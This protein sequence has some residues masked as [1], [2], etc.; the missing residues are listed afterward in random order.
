MRWRRIDVVLRRVGPF[1]SVDLINSLDRS[2]DWT[3]VSVVV[4]GIGIAG[5]AAADAL[6]S[7]GAR[8]HVIDGADT[9]KTRERA[10]IL[11]VLGARITLGDGDTLPDELDV[12]VVSPGLPPSAPVIQAAL[13]RGIPVWGELE[14]AWRL[15]KDE[16]PWLLVT[17][18]NGKTTTTLMLESM[19][20]ASGLRTV[21][22]G[23]IGH[24]LVDVVMHDTVD[25]IAVEVGAPQLPFV[26]TV[27]PLAAVCLNVA[28]DHIDH[29]GS[30]EAYIA[31][32]AKVFERTQIAAVY[33]AADPITL[34]MVEDADVIEGCRAV[35]FT[36]GVPGL[37][38]LGLVDEYLVDRAFIEERQ[39]AAQELAS[40]SDVVPNA[41]H[42]VA[43]ALAAAALARA[44]GV[45]A[46]SI[47]QG[48]R[49]FTPAG[50]RITTVATISE[51]TFVDDSKATNTHAAQTALQA[52]ESVVWIAGGMAKGQEFDELVVKQAHRLRGVVL[53]G[54]DRHVIAQ[55]LARHAPDVPVLEVDRTDT[56]AMADVVSHAARL[57]SPGDTVLLAPGCASWDMFRDYAHRGD[58][59]AAA[60]ASL[61]G[62]A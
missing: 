9:E 28:P 34:Q 62:D 8:V 41:P 17:G 12:L 60:V 54:V 20:A 53:L 1:V 46:E 25:V 57:A 18:T 61:G 48:L 21:S 50:H 58:E 43:N 22:A 49:D 2:S 52:F 29:F 44:C 26:H 59:F 27:S 39:T 36:L 14:L 51:V 42:N 32:K 37:S 23:N 11:D 5:F 4:A 38:M 16:A 45:P 40:I 6:I 47:R 24:S 35:A 7:L 13:E 55:A 31:A 56:G 10:Q 33:N 3:R 30:M 15:R 19:L